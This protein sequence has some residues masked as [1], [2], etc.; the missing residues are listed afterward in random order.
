MERK[1]K[2][3]SLVSQIAGEVGG[4]GGT[5]DPARPIAD[6]DRLDES[7]GKR[8]IFEDIDPKGNPFQLTCARPS[9]M[10]CYVSLGAPVTHRT[11]KDLTP[12]FLRDAKFEVSKPSFIRWFIAKCPYKCGACARKA[13][14]CVY[15]P[16]A[17]GTQRNFK[18]TTCRNERGSTCSW[19]QDLLEVYM[20]ETYQL[21]VGEARVLVSSK[22]NNPQGTLSNYYQTWLPEPAR[23]CSENESRERLKALKTAISWGRPRKRKKDSRVRSAQHSSTQLSLPDPQPKPQKRVKLICSLP[24]EQAPLSQASS[25]PPPAQGP[26]TPALVK[27]SPGVSQLP[28]D[29]AS[30]P[31]PPLPARIPL[32]VVSSPGGLRL[33]S[34]ITD[35]ILEGDTPPLSCSSGLRQPLSTPTLAPAKVSP[36]TTAA[37]TEPESHINTIQDRSPAL[38]HNW[39]AT[40]QHHSGDDPQNAAPNNFDAGTDEVFVGADPHPPSCDIVRLKS[41]T[42]TSSDGLPNLVVEDLSFQED[43]QDA[44]SYLL[45]IL[46][47][48]LRMYDSLRSIVDQQDSKHI[49]VT[50]ILEDRI[51]S[52]TLENRQLKQGVSAKCLEQKICLL[53]VENDQL[54]GRLVRQNQELEDGMLQWSAVKGLEQKIRQLEVEIDQIREEI[55]QR[56]Q[57]IATI[58]AR[59]QLADYVLRLTAQ[60]DLPPPGDT[61]AD[62]N[63]RGLVSMIRARLEKN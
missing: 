58:S 34:T 35:R 52:L 6:S 17:G 42:A 26:S 23:H 18:C 29:R 41:N 20:R 61:R 27:M 55:D 10:P 14:S 25:P 31:P 63:L 57:A 9:N 8:E 50:N 3:G 48:S 37:I 56:E 46:R 24:P 13:V 59:T 7:S 5:R 12:S 60:Q 21:D 30:L 22:E 45:K 15:P 38:V 1:A 11:A 39:H 19:L 43:R 4:S 54:R 32:I 47:G 2:D 53:E 49:A 51:C 33:L 44:E 62:I 28:P 16:V 40:F 36:P